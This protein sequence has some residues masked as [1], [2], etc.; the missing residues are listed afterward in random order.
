MKCEKWRVKQDIK[1]WTTIQLT[2]LTLF[3]FDIRD[4]TFTLAKDKVLFNMSRIMHCWTNVIIVNLVHRTFW[5][6]RY[7]FLEKDIIGRGRHFS[8]GIVEVLI[9]PY[10]E[11]IIMIIQIEWFSLFTMVKNESKWGLTPKNN[12]KHNYTKCFIVNGP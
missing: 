8:I 2:F 6:T 3:S 9:T 5:D 4:S 1:N 10:H 7:I 12:S 11:E